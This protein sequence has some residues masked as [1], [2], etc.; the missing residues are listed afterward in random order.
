MSEIR[1][2]PDKFRSTWWVM[3]L[4][5]FPRIR[6]V[7]LYVIKKQEKKSS[8]KLSVIGKP[9]TYNEK[10]AVRHWYGASNSISCSQQSKN[11]LVYCN[12]WNWRYSQF[13]TKNVTIWKLFFPHI[14]NS[15]F[16][17]SN[18]K[19][20]RLLYLFPSFWYLNVNVST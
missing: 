14:H 10:H 12:C 17:T 8:L 13:Y 15:F 7:C 2:D 16:P 19:K 9:F 20:K 1:C 6:V 11:M 3:S 4:C 5:S 18:F